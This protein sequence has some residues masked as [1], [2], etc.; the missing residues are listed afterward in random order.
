[1]RVSFAAAITTV[2]VFL[3][4]CATPQLPL[5]LNGGALSNKSGKVGIAMAVLPKPNTFFPGADCLLCIGIV[6]A[7][8]SSLTTHAQA[9][10]TDDLAALQQELASLVKKKGAEPVVINEPLDVTTLPNFGTSGPNI[11]RKDFTSLRLKYGVEKLLFVQVSSVGYVRTYASY[12]PTSE[13]KARIS[14]ITSLIDLRSN[15]YDWF[16]PV[17]ALKAA[18]GAWDEAPKYPGLTNAYF[19]AIESHRDEVTKAIAD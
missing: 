7:V 9:L 3:A 6:S 1:M 16:L 12:F 15:T 5:P 10:P 11:A 19:Q 4:G 8:N 13:P 17:T 2:T 14:S 18:D